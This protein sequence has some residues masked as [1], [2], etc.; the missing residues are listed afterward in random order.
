MFR[1][2]KAKA[3]ES[4]AH[5]GDEMLVIVDRAVNPYVVLYHDP[6]GFRAEQVRSLRNKLVAL[7]PDGEAK[8]L[9]LASAVR[10]EGK[11]ATAI[12]LAMAFSELERN[13]VVLVDAD[14]RQP[15]IERFLNL[16]AGP[17]L[18]DVLQGATPLERALRP[19]GYRNLML[20]GAG[21]RTTH[22][23]E[24]LSPSRLEQVFARLKESFQYVVVDTPPVLSCTDAGV[25][26]ARADGTVLVL[27]LERSS[28][29]LVRQALRQLQ[30][31][32]ANLLG[33]FVTELRGADPEADRRL[34]YGAGGAED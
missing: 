11:T 30:D 12:N 25:V 14:L 2:R 5:P 1:S 9:V 18:S 34:A 27:R 24:I 20:L 16:E 4:E 7:N 23:A 6:T 10:G 26:A 3:A 21:T 8:T 29:A 19:V 33:T 22:P 17:G 15:G 28:K 31:L 32:G 13:Q